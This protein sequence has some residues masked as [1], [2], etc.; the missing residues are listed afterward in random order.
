MNTNKKMLSIKRYQSNSIL[1]NGKISLKQHFF[2]NY[3]NELPTI[4]KILNTQTKFTRV[5]P[6]L[7][8]LTC[9][10]GFGALQLSGCYNNKY[11]TQP[12]RNLL[13]KQS[14]L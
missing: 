3:V 5:Y 9:F 7:T 10:T 6:L 14:L 4:N 13:E 12:Y 1:N 11:T 8:V 2:S